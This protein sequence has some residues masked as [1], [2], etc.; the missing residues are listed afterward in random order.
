MNNDKKNKK[1]QEILSNISKCAELYK[2]LASAGKI[3]CRPPFNFPE[4]KMIHF[5]II[6]IYV[7]WKM[8]KFQSD[9]KRLK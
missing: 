5:N 6:S 3:A 9:L 7:Y 1:R 2:H 4:E 8:K